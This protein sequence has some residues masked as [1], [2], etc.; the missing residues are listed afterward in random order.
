M[1][2]RFAF[3]ISRASG[4][5][6]PVRQ[7]VVPGLLGVDDRLEVPRAPVRPAPLQ[8]LQVSAESGGAAG[9]L[10]PLPPPRPGVLDDAQVARHRRHGEAGRVER[11]LVLSHPVEDLRVS[12]G[13]GRSSSIPRGA[14]GPTRPQDVEL[15][16]PGRL[17]ARGLVP[18][19][20]VRARP[21]EH[22][23]VALEGGPR[24]GVLR[25]RAAGL[26]G[27]LAHH[28]VPSPGGPAHRAGVPWAAPGARGLKKVEPP[29]P[30]RGVT[31]GGRA[32]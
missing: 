12:N 16:A 11:A 25:P 30:S 28:E 3:R 23:L 2:T 9:G 32:A 20:A 27:P 22:V 26:L 31:D 5:T 29:E 21:S 7:A 24:A 19:A 1:S 14:V 6:R 8:G 18:R 13:V 15:V 10:V 17:G 4:L